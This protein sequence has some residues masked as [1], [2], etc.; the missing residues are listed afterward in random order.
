M[1]VASFSKWQYKQMMDH[2]NLSRHW[3][4]SKAPT[5]IKNSKRSKGN[6][7]WDADQFKNKKIK[8]KN[9]CPEILKLQCVYR[10]KQQKVENKITIFILSLFYFSLSLLIALF[11]LATL[12]WYVL[13]FEY[14]E[15]II[16]KLHFVF[17]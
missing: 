12:S 7:K 5:P 4:A 3:S 15:V 2:N 8:N 17:C 6:N 9:P 16:I 10:C 11:I 1:E 14:I 13:S